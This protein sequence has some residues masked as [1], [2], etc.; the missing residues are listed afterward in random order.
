MS[1]LRTNRTLQQAAE[2]KDEAVEKDD[3]QDV[4]TD[5][6]TETNTV[7]KSTRPQGRYKK[8]ERGKLVHAYSS[9]DLGGILWEERKLVVVCTLGTCTLIMNILL[10]GF[11]VAQ[12]GQ[13]SLADYCTYYV[14]YSD[15]SC[16]DM[17][18]AQAP[19][20]MLGEVRGHSSRRMASS[21]VRTVFVRG[22]ITQGNGCYQHR[23]DEKLTNIESENKVLHQ[24]AVSMA[25]NKILSGR[26]RS[27]LQRG[28][29]SGHLFVDTKTTLDLHSPSLNQRDLSEVEDKPQKSLNEKQQENQELLIRC[30][31]QH[32]GFA[33]NR[34][35]AACIIYKCLL[36]WRSFEV[37]R[38]SV[39]DRIIQTIGHAIETQDNNDILAYWLSNSSTLL[40]LLQRTLKT[41]NFGGKLG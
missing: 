24:Q 27:I 2:I 35:I 29:E 12:S 6:T 10:E 32:L 25:P 38:T 39:F 18:S 11:I 13:S 26:S 33:G 22:S 31:G 21:L 17:N 5:A 3:V 20:R 36:Q 9:E 30:I 16:T 4:D 8:R 28:G 34:P 1:R 7:V 23:L 40:L 14:A 41:Q 15:G 37:E 19:N